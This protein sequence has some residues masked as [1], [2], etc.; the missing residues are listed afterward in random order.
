MGE[1]MLS[2]GTLE[3]LRDP[4]LGASDVETQIQYLLE[5]E[6]IRRLGRYQRSNAMLTEKYGISFDE[7]TAQHVVEQKGYTWEVEKDAMDWETAMGGLETMRERLLTL[8]KMR[9]V[10]RV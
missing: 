9:E 2:E 5:A 4:V 8:K 10:H 7:F 1:V 3:L 6:Y